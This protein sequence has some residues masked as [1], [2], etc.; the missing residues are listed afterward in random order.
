MTVSSSG[1]GDIT[2]NTNV[3]GFLT[4]DLAGCSTA[5]TGQPLVYSIND[6][7]SGG[8]EIGSGVYFSSSLL[9]QRG[10]STFGLKTTN[11]NS[12]IVMSN[13]AQVYITAAS[14]TYQRPTIQTFLSGSGTYNT[15]NNTTW[16]KI[17]M[18]GAGAGGG[19]S[20]TASTAGSSGGTTSFGSGLLTCTG[21]TNN[22]TGAP[23]GGTASGGDINIAG[24]QATLAVSGS[25]TGGSAGGN[26]ALGGAGAGSF[27]AAGSAAAANSGAGGG[28]GWSA[29]VGNSAVGGSAGGY[30]EKIIT[31]PSTSYPYVVGAGGAAGSSGV[32][33]FGGGAGANGG[34]WVEEHYGS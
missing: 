19:G 9:L 22:T 27:N 12:A 10:S 18:V 33:G 15:P 3:A 29:G 8:S 34:I 7:G 26:S 21:G 6:I 5:S 23:A 1:T 11:S 20:G 4:F 16:L 25:E 14:Y 30:L 13:A 32:S 24:G 31:S 17:K 2:L 28:G